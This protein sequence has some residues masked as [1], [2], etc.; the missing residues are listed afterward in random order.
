MP[1]QPTSDRA[2]LWVET[3]LAGAA[4]LRVPPGFKTDDATDLQR[5]SGLGY[6]E[7]GTNRGRLR[8]QRLL[9][10]CVGEVGYQRR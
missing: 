10:G 6:P 7:S 8:G 4:E 3:L 2:G 5:L 9:I 1:F